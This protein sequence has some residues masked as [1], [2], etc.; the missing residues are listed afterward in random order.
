MKVSGD[1]GTKAIPI[2]G[3]PTP[4]LCS[5]DIPDSHA[6]I[7]APSWWWAWFCKTGSKGEKRTEAKANPKQSQTW[8]SLWNS[9]LRAEGLPLSSCLFLH[10][11][12]CAPGIK[13]LVCTGGT[14]VTPCWM[15]YKL[16]LYFCQSGIRDCFSRSPQTLNFKWVFIYY[17]KKGQMHN[18]SAALSQYTL[19]STFPMSLWVKVCYANSISWVHKSCLRE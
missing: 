3:Q 11:I 9:S 19:I 5:Y 2:L 17:F 7:D 6:V 8:R 12:V 10:A 15:K 4:G 14:K 13:L 16:K 1:G 18:L